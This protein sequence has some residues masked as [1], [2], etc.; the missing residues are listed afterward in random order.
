VPKGRFPKH[1]LLFSTTGKTPFSGFSKAK[2]QLDE[3]A[4]VSEWRLHD[5]RRT[6]A[7]AMSEMGYSIQV[8]ERVLN[9]R[10]MSRSGV[11]GI[12]QRSELLAERKAAIEAWGSR[13]AEIIANKKL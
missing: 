12:Y 1:G 11:V 3:D 7:T 10:G 5:L 8:V 6:A 4:E 9:H 2:A 13:V